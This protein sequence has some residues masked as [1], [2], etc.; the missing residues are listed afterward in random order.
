MILTGTPVQN[1][2]TELF[3]L[4]DFV[5]PGYLGT[6]SSFRQRFAIPITY[7][8]SSLSGSGASASCDKS[9][10]LD[11]KRAASELRRRL[12]HI[13]LRRTSDQILRDILPPRVDVAVFIELSQEQQGQYVAHLCFFHCCVVIFHF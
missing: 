2:L 13:L 4:V 7:Y 11:A 12:A 6:L 3:A 5:C 9:Q 8:R 10:A 1:D